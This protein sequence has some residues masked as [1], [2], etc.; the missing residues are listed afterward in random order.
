MSVR[1]RQISGIILA[2]GES[3]RIGQEKAFLEIGGKTLIGEQKDTLGKIFDEVI[4]VANILD[5]FTNFHSR[6]VKD[7]IPDSGPLGGLYSGLSVSSNVYSFLIGCDM[8]FINL[9]LINYMANQIEDNDIV[10]P[11]TS[12]GIETLFAFYSLA[13]LGTIRR[14]IESNNLRLSDVLYHHKVRYIAQEEIRKIDPQE[15]SFFN[16]N[17]P[18]DYKQA[19]RIWTTK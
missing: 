1:L 3:V 13:C 9:N 16:I 11:L 18:E 14:L 2:G 7:I 15:H 19:K 5:N 17:S 10:V 6:V 8:P 12:R 4:V